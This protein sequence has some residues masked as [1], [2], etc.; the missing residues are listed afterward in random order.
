VNVAI[1]H[2]RGGYVLMK[3]IF[4][5]RFPFMRALVRCTGAIRQLL[6]VSQVLREDCS[7]PWVLKASH[8]ADV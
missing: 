3:Q 2:S 5:R 4:T 1:P 6:V 8:P 7:E